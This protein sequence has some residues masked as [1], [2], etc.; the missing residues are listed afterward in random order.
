MKVNAYQ[1]RKQNE[2]A[3]IIEM[4]KSLG[5]F[6]VFWITQN[7]IRSRVASEMIDIG[8]LVED[9]ESTYP[10]VSAQLKGRK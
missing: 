8:D 7:Q 9:P 2:R 10:W 3:R 1:R 6:S 4:V 5:G